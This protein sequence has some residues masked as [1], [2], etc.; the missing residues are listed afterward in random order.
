MEVK[1]SSIPGVLILMP[2]RFLDAR[3]FSLRAITNKCTLAQ[4][5]IDIELVQD[6]LSLSGTPLTLRGLHFQLESFP[7]SSQIG[8]KL[9]IGLQFRQPGV[10]PVFLREN[11]IFSRNW[12]FNAEIWIVPRQSLIAFWSID[13]GHLVNHLGIWLQCAKS[14]GEALRIQS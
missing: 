8:L 2:K 3:G 11:G 6:N 14:V 9:E 13:V 7:Q 5:G 4:A 1:A 10:A 12:P